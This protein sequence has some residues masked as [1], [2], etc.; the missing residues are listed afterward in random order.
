MG[1][2]FQSIYAKYIILSQKY[3]PVFLFLHNYLLISSDKLFLDLFRASMYK[4]VPRTGIPEDFDDGQAEI[5]PSKPQIGYLQSP[6]LIWDNDK[7]T[8]EIT[9]RF[10]CRMIV[11]RS[12]SL[13]APER[14]LNVAFD[15]L[16]RYSGR[17]IGE[18]LLY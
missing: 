11:M 17:L 3:L 6:Y 13:T 15:C 18:S 8:D 4:R 1:I 10:S 2:R 7:R 14:I 5:C 12:G 9:R 16:Q